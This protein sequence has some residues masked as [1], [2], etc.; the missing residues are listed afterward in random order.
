MTRVQHLYRFYFKIPIVTESILNIELHPAYFAFAVKAPNETIYSNAHIEHLTSIPANGINYI[1]LSEWLK[2][3]Q[4]IWNKSYQ[5]IFIAIHG[6]PVS[7][8]P[9]KEGG[10]ITLEKLHAISAEDSA[11]IQTR[12]KDDFIWTMSLPQNLKKLL[13]SYFEGATIVPSTY[14]ISRYIIEHN[15]HISLLN[16]HI[17]PTEGHFLYITGRHPQYYNCFKY[18]N[19]DDLLYFTLLTYKML[20]LTPETY[21]LTLS[22]LVEKDSEVFQLLYQYIR[23]VYITDY[24]VPIQ[25]PEDNSAVVQ[26]NYLANLLYTAH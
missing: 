1:L 2:G 12:L 14:G 22:G 24:P 9:D 8:T 13:D 3:L 11:V 6:Y 21:P 23:N 15:N 20:G 10:T 7:A 17:T 18:K 19:K 25:L 5:K 26:P 16:L 4:N